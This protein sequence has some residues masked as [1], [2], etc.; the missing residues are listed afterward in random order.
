MERY[1]LDFHAGDMRLIFNACVGGKA[2]LG[3]TGEHGHV[4]ILRY[5]DRPIVPVLSHDKSVILTFMPENYFI[6]GANRRHHQKTGKCK[7]RPARA[8]NANQEGYQRHRITVR[9]ALEE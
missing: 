9:E 7:Q 5:M 4:Y 2:I 3:R 8:R 1:G 6:A